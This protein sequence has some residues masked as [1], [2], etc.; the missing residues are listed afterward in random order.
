[1]LVFENREGVRMSR[2]RDIKLIRYLLREELD[3]SHRTINLMLLAAAAAMLPTIVTTIL[4][5]T[6]FQ[7][8]ASLVLIFVILAF[9]TWLI[10]KKPDSQLP[11]FI[12]C[13]LVNIVVFPFLY[14]GCGGRYT[15]MILWMLLGAVFSFM[16][17]KKVWLVV[18]YVLNCLNLGA[19][20][21]LGYKFPEKVQKLETPEAECFDIVFCFFIIVVLIGL[22]FKYQTRLYV[23]EHQ[24]LLQKEE[25]LK[26]LNEELERASRAKSDFLANMSHE[27]R[28]PINA[29]LGMDEMILRDSEDKAVIEYAEDIEAAGRQLLS[30]IND[31]L[32]FSKIESGKFEIHEEEY[33]LLTLIND[34]YNLVIGRAEAKSLSL[35]VRNDPE[36]PERL[37]GDTVRIKQVL[38]NLLTNAIKYTEEGKVEIIFSGKPLD[39]GYIL[40]E[41][42]VKDTGV[43]ILKEDISKLFGSFERIDEKEHRNIEGTGLGLAITKQLTELMGGTIGVESVRGEGSEFYISIPQKVVSEKKVG[44]FDVGMAVKRE[45]SKKY[46]ASFVAPAANV[47]VVDDV[48]INLNVVR[49]LLRDTKV[50]LDLAESGKEALNL[51]MEKKYDVVLMDHMMPEMDGIQT[52]KEARKICEPNMHTPM[53]ALTANAISGAEA[54]YRKAGFCEYITKPIKA[55]DLEAALVRR[56]PSEK[57]TIK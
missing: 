22:V 23:K 24:S 27:I 13:F 16:L 25:E 26:R 11:I 45:T 14:F 37:Y 47:L 36:L 18:S 35:I 7:G 32:D 53:I 19:C 31:I 49:L 42:S 57:V 52:L 34:C 30:L 50:K 2:L 5:D 44:L 28:T 9:F 46:R 8:V 20:V 56:L 29:V 3:I 10:N 1:M 55:P 6:S 21:Y 4:L 17:L 51:M 15:G 41:V 54:I 43:G 39:E 40:F 48:K 33:D 12:C 38:I